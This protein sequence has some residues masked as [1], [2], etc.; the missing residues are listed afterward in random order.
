[1]RIVENDSVDH[2]LV[3]FLSKDAFIAENGKGRQYCKLN[4]LKV[5]PR[6]Q[7]CRHQYHTVSLCLNFH[8]VADTSRAVS[9]PWGGHHSDLFRSGVSSCGQ[10]SFFLPHLS[11]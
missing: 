10:S 4:T 7:S 8:A 6:G 3:I 2:N 5:G 11:L 1:M 9:L